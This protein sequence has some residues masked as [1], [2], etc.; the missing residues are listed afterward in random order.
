MDGHTGRFGG[1]GAAVLGVVAVG[2]CC[3]APLVI[4][5]GA[6]LVAAVGWTDLGMGAGMAL[7]VASAIL[8][9]LRF[10]QLRRPPRSVTGRQPDSVH[11]ER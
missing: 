8:A 7:L 10:P 6:A 5:V 2:L 4:V 3:G 1:M 11:K 9:L